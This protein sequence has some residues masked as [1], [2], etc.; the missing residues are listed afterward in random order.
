[1][2][3]LWAASGI[4]FSIYFVGTDGSVPL[5]VQPQLFTFFCLISW[6]QTLYYPPVQLSRKKLMIYTASF[7]VVS[8]A[9]EVGFILWLRPVHRGGK[10]WP[11]LIVGIIACILLTIGLIPPYFELAKRQ[12]R[13]VGINFVFLAL[14]SGGALFSILSIV[15][16]NMDI[17]SIVLYAMVLALE[18][19]IAVSHI[20]WY[21][22]MGRGIIRQ[23]KAQALLEKEAQS[24]GLDDSL[25]PADSRNS[26]IYSHDK[27]EGNELA[28]QRTRD[29]GILHNDV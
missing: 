2:M 18:L 20:L 24:A 26:E 4:P 10:H 14:D 27:L 12:G 8:V 16:G 13:V 7:V 3:F 11:M 19:G 21:L 1:M 17:M 15:F 22:R 23:E 5:R 25:Q 29:L 6:V 9:L 28:P